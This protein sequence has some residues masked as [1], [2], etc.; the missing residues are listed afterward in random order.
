V[1][2]SEIEVDERLEYTEEHVAII[3]RREKRLRNKTIQLVKVQWKHQ[4]GSEATWEAE[5]EM[6]ENFPRLFDV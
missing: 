5:E 2:L 3:D 4:R 1:P 6:S